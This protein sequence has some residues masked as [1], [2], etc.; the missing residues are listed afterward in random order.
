MVGVH[1]VCLM[2]PFVGAVA[3][4]VPIHVQIFPLQRFVPP[5]VGCAVASQIRSVFPMASRCG[6]RRLPPCA[7]LAQLLPKIV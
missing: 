5:L 4:Q 1:L 7:L 3:Q 2:L 6:N